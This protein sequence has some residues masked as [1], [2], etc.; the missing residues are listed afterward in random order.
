MPLAAILPPDAEQVTVELVVPETEDENCCWAPVSKLAAVG[1]P[2]TWILPVTGGGADAVTV[3]TADPGV[4][5]AEL[6]RL[7]E[8]GSIRRYR[9]GACGRGR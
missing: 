8:G 4:T 7:R 5:P 3:T 6:R 2:E 9:V 1:D